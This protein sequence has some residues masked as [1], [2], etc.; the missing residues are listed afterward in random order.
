MAFNNFSWGT[1]GSD[2]P[3]DEAPIQVEEKEG[4]FCTTTTFPDDQTEIDTLY[5]EYVKKSKPETRQEKKAKPKVLR[6]EEDYFK[7]FRSRVVLLWTFSNALLIFF[8]TFTISTD[9][10]SCLK[11]KPLVVVEDANGVTTNWYLAGI[12]WG[13]AG[14]STLR[15]CGSMTYLTKG[16]FFS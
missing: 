12:L 1:K 5:D 10:T 16:V 3:A 9:S 6:V 8:M 13:V 11:I 4:K 2:K 14:L 15:F 7:M